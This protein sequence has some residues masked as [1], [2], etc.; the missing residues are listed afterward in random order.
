[1]NAHIHHLS[2]GIALLLIETNIWLWGASTCSQTEE[3][4]LLV[5]LYWIK[6][7]KISIKGQYMAFSRSRS[8]NMEYL[9][10]S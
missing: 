6:D 5:H 7:C 9:P 4:I 8:Q 1:M 2:H 3:A 10:N